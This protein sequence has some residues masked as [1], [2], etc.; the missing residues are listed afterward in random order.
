MIRRLIRSWGARVAVEG[1]SMQPTLAAGD[2]LL[3]TSANTWSASPAIVAGELVQLLSVS[4]TTHVHS[5]S[6]SA[7]VTGPG[8]KW[9]ATVTITVRDNGVGIDPKYHDKVFGL[10]ERLDA[11][12]EGTGIG[13]AIAQALA[14]GGARVAWLVSDVAGTIAN[15]DGDLTLVKTSDGPQQR[16]A[17]RARLGTIPDYAA[18]VEGLLLGGVIGAQFG[19]RA[20]R[21]LNVESFRL[22]LALLTVGSEPTPPL[23]LNA[24][25]FTIGGTLGLIW[26]AAFTAMTIGQLNLLTISFAILFIGLGVDFGIHL[27]TGYADQL[28]AGAT[29]A[30]PSCWK[31]T[32]RP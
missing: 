22:L 15:R 31:S 7:L 26:T 4:G 16:M 10:F 3:L 29:R 14:E 12:T 19:G 11:E 9:E 28:R 32:N 17:L 20:A 18:E 5:L 8:S 1:D 21:N 30:C 23:L 24:I 25:C 2:W 13:L 6:G 27:C